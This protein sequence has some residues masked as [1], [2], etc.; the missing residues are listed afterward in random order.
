MNN[1]D[2]RKTQRSLFRLSNHSQKQIHWRTPRRYQLEGREKTEKSK[3]PHNCILI[4]TD[5]LHVSILHAII[6]IIV[7]FLSVTDSRAIIMN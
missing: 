6:T 7:Y 3:T 1:S 2:H 5:L 4:A